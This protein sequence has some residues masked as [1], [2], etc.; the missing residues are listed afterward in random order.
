MKTFKFKNYAKDR[1]KHLNAAKIARGLSALAKDVNADGSDLTE[2]TDSSAFLEA[3]VDRALNDKKCPWRGALTLDVDQAA[4]KTWRE[5]CRKLVQA[6]EYVVVPGKVS[7]REIVYIPPS[8]SGKNGGGEYIERESALNRVDVRQRY[9]QTALDELDRW[10][11][12]YSDLKELKPIWDAIEG[13]K[14][15]IALK[16]AG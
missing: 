3:M 10:V 5:E 11:S 9:V 14:S 8:K 4:R 1:L 15:Q 2:L 12:K 16:K 13:A 6:L 7:K